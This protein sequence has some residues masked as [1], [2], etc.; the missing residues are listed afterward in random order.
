MIVTS[1]LEAETLTCMRLLGAKNISELGPRF[2]SHPPPSYR[3]SM[4]LTRGKGEHSAGGEGYLRWGPGAGQAG[5]VGEAVQAVDKKRSVGESLNR[6]AYCYPQF[7]ANTLCSWSTGSDIHQRAFIRSSRG[8]PMCN[9][10]FSIHPLVMWEDK[11]RDDAFPR[12][13]QVCGG[14][15]GFHMRFRSRLGG[16]SSS[17]NAFKQRALGLE[18]MLSDVIWCYMGQASVHRGGLRRPSVTRGS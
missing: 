12:L 3:F 6:Y 8:E 4:P 5:L 1:V 17:Y 11:A 7:N 15:W 18:S 2:V 13:L 9:R 16:R 10:V 14:L